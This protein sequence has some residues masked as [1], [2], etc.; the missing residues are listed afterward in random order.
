[1]KNKMF[2]ELIDSVK[3]AGAIY[4]GEA[5]ASRTFDFP[6]PDVKAIREKTG[7]T[8]DEFARLIAV[9]VK[10]LQNWEQER[11]T[12]TGAARVLLKLLEVDTEDTIRKIHTA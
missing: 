12:P 3:E 7:Q 1:M 4:K 10:T 6:T 9:S 2:N 8:Q 11:R 5:E